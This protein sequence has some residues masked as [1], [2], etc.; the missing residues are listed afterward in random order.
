MTRLNNYRIR[1]LKGCNGLEKDTSRFRTRNTGG[2]VHDPSCKHCGAVREDAAHFICNCSALAEVQATLLLA[3]PPTISSLIPDPSA[4]PVEFT[5]LMLGT[6]WVDNSEL[7]SF[8]VSFLD[9]LRL[10]RVHKL[11]NCTHGP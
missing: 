3:A 8:C 6:C 7:Q 10:A 9:Q 4:I 2:R 5:A 11:L 1:L